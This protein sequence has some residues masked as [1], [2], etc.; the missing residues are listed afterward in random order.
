MK[1][2]TKTHEWAE[3]SGNT[4]KVGISIYAAEELG[5]IVY[6][7]LPSLG[8]Q[9]KEG[10]NMC[11]VESVKAV[12]EINAPVSGK[13]VAVNDVLENNPEKINENALSAWICEIQIDGLPNGLMTEEEYNSMVK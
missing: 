12:S 5:D 1:K 8:A 6:V 7:E 4:A 2:Y 3:I 11:E 10:E 9:V 13:I